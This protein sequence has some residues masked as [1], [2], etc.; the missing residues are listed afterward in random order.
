MAK[1]IT[2]HIEISQNLHEKIKAYAYENRMTQKAVVAEAILKLVD[3][4]EEIH[5]ETTD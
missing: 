5:E 4:E 3:G 2:T 1:E